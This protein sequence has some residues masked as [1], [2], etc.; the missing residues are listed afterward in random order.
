MRLLWLGALWFGGAHA[1][2]TT[3]SP[4][5]VRA[6]AEQAV[7]A[8]YALPGSRIVVTAAPLDPRLQLAACAEPL[9]AIVAGHAEAAPRMTVPV[10]CPQP[11]G[12][13]VRVPLQLQLFRTVLVTN[14]PLLRGDGLGAADV[15]A[16][17]RDVTR[18]GYGY[19]ENL[20][21]VAGRTLNR[22]VASGS[23]LTPGALGGRRMVRAGD[24]VQMVAR[25]GGIEVRVDGVALGSGDNG[26]R[27]RVRNE[28]SGKVVDAM[29]SAP[30]EVLALP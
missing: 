21:Q 18:L 28:S 26:A 11:G 5:S 16:E 19:L 15:H 9:R 14:R 27:L 20:D 10:Q 30:G 4:D 1:A 7:R 24:H 29:V 12:W 25:L 13:I 6:A 22:A 8:H 23:V 17:E 3:Q 2:A